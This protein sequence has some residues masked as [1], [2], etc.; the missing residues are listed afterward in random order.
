MSCMST[1]Y[2]PGCLVT[3]SPVMQQFFCFIKT[4]V[5]SIFLVHEPYTEVLS[6]LS[7]INTLY[8]FSPRKLNHFGTALVAQCSTK[9]APPCRRPRSG[10]WVPPAT[11]QG[12]H[13][14]TEEPQG[15]TETWCSCGNTDTL[16]TTRNIIIT[17]CDF[18]VS[19]TLKL[20]VHLS[21]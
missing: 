12:P 18:C 17:P 2:E 4:H 15:A 5:Y 11:T 13:A 3:G 10:S 7:E 14:P 9:A 1:P 6:S 20:P 21:A 16:K 19:L 8:K